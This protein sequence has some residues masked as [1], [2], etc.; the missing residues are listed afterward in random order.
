[1][2]VLATRLGANDSSMLKVKANGIVLQSVLSGRVCAVDSVFF[3]CLR[4]NNTEHSEIWQR[5]SL[6]TECTFRPPLRVVLF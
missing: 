6:T 2:L 5:A 1:M 3:P 4:D